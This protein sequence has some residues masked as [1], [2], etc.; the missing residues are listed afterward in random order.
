MLAEESEV[1]RAFSPQYIF[2]S[3]FEASRLLT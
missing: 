3:P 2:F 1:E